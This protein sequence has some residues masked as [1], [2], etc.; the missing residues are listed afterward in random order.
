[1]MQY[2][3]RLSL[4]LFSPLIQEK[5]RETPWSMAEA[6]PNQA[7]GCWL[8]TFQSTDFDFDMGHESLLMGFNHNFFSSLRK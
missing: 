8:N 4:L 6:A 7:A 1:M 5:I 3:L 2:H